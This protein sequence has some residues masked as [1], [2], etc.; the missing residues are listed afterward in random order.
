MRIIGGGVALG[1]CVCMCK[2]VRYGGCI[3]L[4]FM[5]EN[6]LSLDKDER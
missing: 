2:R 3:M 5:V 4:K 1:R 6:S